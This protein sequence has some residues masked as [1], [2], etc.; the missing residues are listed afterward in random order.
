M[1]SVSVKIL[2][3]LNLLGNIV[4]LLPYKNVK[5]DLAS[6]GSFLFVEY[7]ARGIGSSYIPSLPDRLSFK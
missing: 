5:G 6:Q 2:Y 7:F 1:V 4:M 3:V